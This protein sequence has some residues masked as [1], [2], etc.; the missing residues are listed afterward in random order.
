MKTRTEILELPLSDYRAVWDL[1][2]NMVEKRAAGQVQDAL[3]LVEHPHVFTVGKGGQDTVPP[4]IHGV[5]VHKVE[6]G[7]LWTYHGPGQLV[8]YPILNLDERERDIRRYLRDLERTIILTV[9]NFGIVGDR[10]EGHT[11]VWVGSKKLASIGVAVRNWITFHGFALN[12]S[13]DLKYFDMI[14][15]CG[16]P[17]ATLTSMQQLLGHYVPMDNVKEAFKAAFEEVFET[18]LAQPV[19]LPAVHA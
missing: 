15:P 12:V 19:E 5:P 13:T 10:R 1:Q 6:R 7:G 8:G 3:I 11:G 17:S 2:L 16:L 9:Q 18:G 14:E 4:D